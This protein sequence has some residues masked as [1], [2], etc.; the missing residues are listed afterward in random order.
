M[1]LASSPERSWN[2]LNTGY[3]A[4]IHVGACLVL[5]PSNFSW[6]AIGIAV[7]LHWITGGLG[8]TLGWHRLVSHRSFTT[9]KWVEYFF[10]LCGALACQGGVLDWVGLH[11][12]HHK[13]S[14]TAPDP[15][16]SSLGFF[17]SHFG[18][19]FFYAQR[20]DAVPRVTKDIKDDPVY[21]FLNDYFVL[22]QVALGLGLFAIGGW[23]YI[24][25]CIFFRLVAVFHC[26]WLVNSATHMFGY[27]T[28][29]SDDKS[30]NCWWVALLTY[31]EG[32]HN[33]HHAYQYSAR[34]GLKWWEIDLTWMTI[35]FLQMLGLATN[36]KLA[37]VEPQQA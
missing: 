31:G 18:W 29:N 21:K 16:D 10:V 28:F 26:T 30:R 35:R 7:L 9:P 4:L 20:G 14:D 3:L 11:R 1:T 13:Y 23:P 2:W 22:I 24:A 25:W 34:H 27:R 36:V 17:W 6:S 33:N 8:I 32:W 5:I 12:L 19:M 37:P 15:H